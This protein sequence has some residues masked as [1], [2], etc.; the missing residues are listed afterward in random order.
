MKGI[1]AVSR[2]QLR[3][4]AELLQWNYRHAQNQ[5]TRLC[6]LIVRFFTQSVNPPRYHIYT[7]PLINSSSFSRAWKGTAASRLAR[8]C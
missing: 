5:V 6:K 8:D 4:R 2:S 3:S 7:E 1:S